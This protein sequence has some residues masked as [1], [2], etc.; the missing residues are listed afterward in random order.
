MSK[1]TDFAITDEVTVDV[2][3]TAEFTTA[4]QSVERVAAELGF[5]TGDRTNLG[6]VAVE[7][8]ANLHKHAGGGT[9]NIKRLS[10]GSRTGIRL[11]AHTPAPEIQNLE[12]TFTTESATVESLGLGLSTVNQTMDELTVTTP[13]GTDSGTRLVADRWLLPKHRTSK[14]IPAS[15]GAASRGISSDLPNGD[16]FIF[17]AWNDTAL[18]GVIDGL[19]HGP[20]AH[21]AS[22][23]ARDYIE[24]HAEQPFKS[25]F[26][27]TDHAC[28]GTRSVVMA[29][30][31]F[32]WTEETL[33]F[34]NVG[35][36]KVT[37]TG[38]EWT[39][40][41]LR[42]GVIGGNSPEPAVV[43]RE[44]RPSYTMI[45]YSDGISTRRE[46]DDVRENADASAGL[47]ANR[48]LKQYGESDDDATVLV[49]TATSN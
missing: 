38:P 39:G 2:T 37:V 1:P 7:L 18:V 48:I 49:V 6:D 16:A 20:Q 34:A 41:I 23:T 31:K 43:T 10:T 36:I 26:R 3:E 4:R 11:E 13:K 47:I 30:A 17:K 21:Q 12:A 9:L 42:R 8:A 25:I 28:N 27:G 46:W 33:T 24:S 5:K 15:I 40:F 32:D 29:L 22:T 35:N 14:P 19:G 45:L 44:W